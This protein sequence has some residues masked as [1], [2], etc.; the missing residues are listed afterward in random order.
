MERKINVHIFE[1]NCT[2][3]ILCSLTPSAIRSCQLKMFNFSPQLRPNPLGP[4]HPPTSRSRSIV[5]SV[6]V[7]FALRVLRSRIVVSWVASVLSDRMVGGLLVHLLRG[8]QYRFGTRRLAGIPVA[9][10]SDCNTCH[11][12]QCLVYTV[13]APDHHRQQLQAAELEHY[14]AAAACS[15]AQVASHDQDRTLEEVAWY[16]AVVHAVEGFEQRL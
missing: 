15:P 3:R 2:T 13:V 8:G 14:R 5:R 4:I 9:A 6:I 12:L 11:R 16:F 7:F 1:I 10:A